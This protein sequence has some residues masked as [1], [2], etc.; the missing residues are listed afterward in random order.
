MPSPIR[1]GSTAAVLA[2]LMLTGAGAGTLPDGTAIREDDIARLAAIDAAAGGALRGAFAHGASADA[3]ALAAALAGAPLSADEAR[4]LLPGDWS[5]QM[6]KL[7][8]GLPIV[9]Y[10]PFRCRADPAGG[11]EKLTGSQ[12]SLGTVHLDGDDLVYLA[13]GFVAGET[14][15]P[16]HALPEEVDIAASPQFVPEVGVVEIVSAGKGRIILPKPYLESDLNILV[17]RR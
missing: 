11:F 8:G 12:R 15:P 5:C 6:M 9:V 14:P 2:A 16:Y 10:Q 1:R 3:A 4:R 7:G 13:T 17:L